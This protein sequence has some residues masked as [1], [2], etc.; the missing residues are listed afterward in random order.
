MLHNQRD[1]QALVTLSG[2]LST[3]LYAEAVT[4]TD[5]AP[6]EYVTPFDVVNVPAETLNLGR[7]IATS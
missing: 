6:P 4:L 1:L 5:V 7:E 3:N 2:S